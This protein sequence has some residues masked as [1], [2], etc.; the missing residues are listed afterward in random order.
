MAT[1]TQIADR[2]SG[3]I[4]ERDAA[5]L[6]AADLEALAAGE[7]LAIRLAGFY[8]AAA[9]HTV[10]GRVQGTAQS[11][12]DVAPEVA[13]V[14]MALFEA[15]DAALLDAYYADAA[16]AEERAR[17]LYGELE[18]PIAALRTL[19]DRLW[20]AGCGTERLHDRPMYAGLVRVIDTASELR[21]HQDNTDWDMT[22]SA[23]AQ[24]MRTQFSAN[25]YFSAAEAGGELEL[26][27]TAIRDGEQYRAI[28]VPG[29]YALSRAAIGAPAL[30][31]RPAAGDLVIFDAR[32]IHAVAPVARGS[33][34]NA[35]T[36]IGL[37]GPDEPLTLFS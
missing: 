4:A 6:C 13:K 5:T 28:K 17:A 31:I 34:V 18:D 12:Y 22:G 15:T 14:G 29:D 26:W 23:R 16:H 2:T 10:S 32:R 27:A 7:V 8:P 36:F 1:E 24:T 11:R 33:R 19:L 3:R 35:S 25:V 37:R 9:C 20:P 30:T 21:P